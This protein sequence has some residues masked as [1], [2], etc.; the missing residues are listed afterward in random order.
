MDILS[1][2]KPWTAIPFRTLMLSVDFCHISLDEFP[3]S[4]WAFSHLHSSPAKQG[5]AESNPYSREQL[6]RLLDLAD[7]GIEK[8]QLEQ[9][10][11]LGDE[12]GR[13]IRED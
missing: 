1:H 8:L 9:R 4:I 7:I 2:S 6:N 13:L 11:V 3:L 10:E 12:L 5:T